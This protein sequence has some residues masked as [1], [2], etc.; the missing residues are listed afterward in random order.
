MLFAPSGKR[1]K[2]Q[3]RAKKADFWPISRKGG[4]TPLKPPFV[5]PPFATAQL[6]AISH[7]KCLNQ[8]HVQTK[9][10]FTKFSVFLKRVS[11]PPCVQIALQAVRRGKYFELIMHFVADTDADETCFGVTAPIVSQSFCRRIRVRG[12][13]NTP[14]LKHKSL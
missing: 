6:K 11:L 8:V 2:R 5:T 13:W 9:K 3:K 1:A 4:Q 10:G 7:R 12:R 14:N